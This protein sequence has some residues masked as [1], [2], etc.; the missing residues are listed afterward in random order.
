MSLSP[1]NTRFIRG[2]LLSKPVES[3]A[4]YT[5]RAY[6]TEVSRARVWREVLVTGTSADGEAGIGLKP[7]GGTRP[8][9]QRSS[10]T[11]SA[12]RG[13]AEL[14]CRA[15]GA[16]GSYGVGVPLVSASRWSPYPSVRT[17]GFG[18][19]RPL[20]RAFPLHPITSALTKL[21]T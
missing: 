1:H 15:V 21:L 5:E 11:P 10:R 14:E 19:S 4:G 17:C 12:T 8:V 18:H 20:L 16:L 13:A 7:G 9:E 2:D 6:T 3:H